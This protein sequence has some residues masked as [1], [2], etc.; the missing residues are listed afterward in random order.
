MDDVLRK[1]L[2]TILAI[3][4]QALADTRIPTEFGVLGNSP[5]ERLIAELR[6]PAGAPGPQ[7]SPGPAGSGGGSGT[8]YFNLVGTGYIGGDQTGDARGA[9]TLDVQSSHG[10]SSQ[11]AS[12]SHA[13]AFGINSTA[14]GDYSTA[15][16][17]KNTSSGY[18]SLTLGRNCQATMYSSTA[19]GSSTSATADNTFAA[20]NNCLASGDSS[21]AA[22]YT[23]TASGASSV[24]LGSEA[25]A[26]GTYALA[27]A[28]CTFADPLINTTD[29]SVEIGADNTNKIHVDTQGLQ[30]AGRFLPQLLSRTLSIDAKTVAATTL[31]TV[32]TGR[33]AVI[34]GVIIRC[35]VATAVTVVATARL[36]G[37]SGTIVGATALTGLD[38]A[39]EAFFLNVANSVFKLQ[40]ATDLIQLDITV[41]ATATTQTFTV[42]LLGY[43]V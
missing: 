11:V 17:Y 30:F 26:S 37:T 10:S 4:E 43:L 6:G 27:I 12:G 7:G 32:P 8:S 9:V 39:T 15:A 25:T 40:V 34:L 41:G 2:E 38:T 20:G 42:D 14:S 33:S 29:H 16:G 24:A 36:I 23:A 1:R 18:Y 5:L 19:I 31:Y 21:V 28:A 22:G 35:T 13:S 3:V